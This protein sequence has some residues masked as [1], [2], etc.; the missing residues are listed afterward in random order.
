MSDHLMNGG[1]YCRNCMGLSAS[2]IVHGGKNHPWDPGDLGRCLL[3]S[4][5]PPFHMRTRSPE[6]ALF[7]DHWT[8][9]AALLAEERP[10]GKAPKTYELMKEIRRKGDEI[11]RGVAT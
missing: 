2:A 3:V 7:V 10:T 9:L 1:D 6:W 8:E 5:M 11:R 4:P